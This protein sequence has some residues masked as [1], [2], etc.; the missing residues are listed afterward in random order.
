MHLKGLPFRLVTDGSLTRRTKWL[1]RCLLVEIP[2]SWQ[3]NEQVPSNPKV[4]AQDC[5]PGRR[6]VSLRHSTLWIIF[7]RLKSLLFRGWLLACFHGQNKSGFFGGPAFI[8]PIRAIWKVFKKS[9]L[10][11]KKPTLQKSYF[12]FDHVNRLFISRIILYYSFAE[13]WWY[14]ETMHCTEKYSL[15]LNRAVLQQQCW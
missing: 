12:C 11:G 8:Q 15:T 13:D 2:V 14:H 7:D 5:L 10:A 4:C 1:F 9:W 6:D 3:I